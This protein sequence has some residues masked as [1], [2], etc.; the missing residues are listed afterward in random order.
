VW[1]MSYPLGLLK[2]TQKHAM[3]SS[4]TIHTLRVENTRGMM[5]KF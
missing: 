2:N 1:V 4:K 3:T 5:D